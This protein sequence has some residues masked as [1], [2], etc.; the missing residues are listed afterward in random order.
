MR[1]GADVV[2]L[3]A[4]VLDVLVGVRSMLLP[5]GVVVGVALSGVVVMVG[6]EDSGPD[7]AGAVGGC[8]G[9]GW[10]LST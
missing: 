3:G 4:G 1:G 5:S 10:S 2:S 9:P 8:R 7:G 6:V